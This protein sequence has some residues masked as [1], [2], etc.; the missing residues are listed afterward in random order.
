MRR[1]LKAVGATVAVVAICV[2]LTATSVASASGP[3]RGPQAHPASGRCTVHNSWIQL[4]YS[5]NTVSAQGLAGSYCS[6]TV[7]FQFV[8]G[9]LQEFWLSTNSWHS[10]ATVNGNTTGA[11]EWSWAYPTIKCKSG[12]SRNWRL[13]GTAVV[14]TGNGD[15]YTQGADNQ[16]LYH[17]TLNCMA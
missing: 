16:P 1:S 11:N 10:M 13:Y 17:N 3:R 14:E 8:S 5:G 12:A 15:Y 9:Q 7:R 6:P 2:G 4:K